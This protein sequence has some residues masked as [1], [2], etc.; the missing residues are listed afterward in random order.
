MSPNISLN[1]DGGYLTVAVTP[2]SGTCAVLEDVARKSA[3]ELAADRGA[4]RDRNA[5]SK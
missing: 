2:L 5:Y 3:Q 1:A 4:V